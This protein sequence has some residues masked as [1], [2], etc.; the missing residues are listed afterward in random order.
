M[1]FAGICSFIDCLSSVEKDMN[2]RMLILFDNE[3]CGSL[4]SAGAEST[5]VSNTIQRIVSEYGNSVD[6]SLLARSFLISADMAHSVHPNYSD[7]HD[8]CHRPKMHKGLVIKYN[9]NQRYATNSH[10]AA[11]IK[12]LAKKAG[13]TT[14]DFMVRNDSPCGTTIGP[15]LSAQLGILAADVGAPQLSMHSIREMA[16]T[17]DLEKSIKLFRTFFENGCPTVDRL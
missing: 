2:V 1:S 3:E 12:Q 13:V 17:E 8:E 14:Q 6:N 9:S 16:G 10:S 15:I 7:K 5:L 11:L 4:S